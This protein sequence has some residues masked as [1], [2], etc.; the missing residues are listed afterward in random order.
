MEED[1]TPEAINLTERRKGKLILVTEQLSE[2]VSEYEGLVT[3][4]R[5]MLVGV[6][7]PEKR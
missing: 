7:E 6:C 5:D 3:A 4:A 1:K 2:E